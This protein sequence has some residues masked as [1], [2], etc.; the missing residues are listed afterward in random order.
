MSITAY[1]AISLAKE[2]YSTVRVRGGCMW[3]PDIA[4]ELNRL[5]PPIP[6]GSALSWMRQSR[7]GVVGG[8][9][10]AV[11]GRGDALEG[12]MSRR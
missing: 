10:F 3:G 9:A 7:R 1:S 6:S 12:E 11:L 8:C 4:E 2:A 5:C